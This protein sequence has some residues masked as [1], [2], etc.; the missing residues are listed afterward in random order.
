M[1][2]P[3]HHV[4]VKPAPDRRRHTEDRLSHSTP[5]NS[6]H[7]VRCADPLFTSQEPAGQRGEPAEIP[8][9]AK[10]GHNANLPIRLARPGIAAVVV[11]VAVAVAEE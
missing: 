3:S 10:S 4:R 2:K 5:A 7:P 1:F 11:A 8:S 9:S 6:R